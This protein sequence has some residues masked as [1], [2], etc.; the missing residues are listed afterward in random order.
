[1]GRARALPNGRTR[2][3]PLQPTQR[4]TAAVGLAGAARL[5]ADA[6][7]GGAAACGP[8]Q[9]Y[10]RKAYDVANYRRAIRRACQRLGLLAWVPGQLRHAAASEF[11]RR[12]G[13]DAAQAL[14]GHREQGIAQVY[15][16]VYSSTARRIVLEA[17]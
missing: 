1:A 6:L 2:G 5:A 17:G 4:G 12:H 16:E 7:A 13:L 10:A 3:L 8:P 9:A 15:A 11:R 14:L